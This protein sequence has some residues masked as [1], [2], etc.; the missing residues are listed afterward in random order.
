V[1]AK[2]KRGFNSS[3][4]RLLQENRRFAASVPAGAYVLD[5]GAGEAPYRHLFAHAHYES[6]DFGKVDKPYLE[7]TYICDLARIPVEDGRFDFVLFNQ[8][9]EHLPRP[10]EVLRELFR[11]L[12]PGGRLLYTGP[13]FYEEHEKPYDFYRYTQFGVRHLFAGSGFTVERIDW[14]EGYYGTLAYQL[15]IAARALSPRA[16]DYGGGCAGLLFSSLTRVLR[17][18]F[19]A[20]SPL[21]HRMEMR[22]KFTSGGHPKNYVAVVSKPS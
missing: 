11:T 4:E 9:M 18:L 14:L 20:L 2:R 5:A 17:V 13:L 15:G 10:E 6:A 19:G 12:K 1:A 16:G 3:R 21:F 7:Q 8:V 22:H